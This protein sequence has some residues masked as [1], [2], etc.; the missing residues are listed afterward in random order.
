MIYLYN[1]CITYVFYKIMLD[2][3]TSTSAQHDTA[4][5]SNTGP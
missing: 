1:L 2:T 4:D 3:L 5:T